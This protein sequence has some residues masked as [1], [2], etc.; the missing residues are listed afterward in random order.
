MRKESRSQKQNFEDLDDEFQEEQQGYIALLSGAL[1]RFYQEDAKELFNDGK[2]ID[3]R[4]M[5]GCIS[6][7]VWCERQWDEFGNLEP[8]VDV[9]YNKMRD[10]DDK[11]VEK[12]FDDC[13]KEDCDRRDECWGKIMLRKCTYSASCHWTECE[14]HPYGFR[15]D[16]IVHKRGSHSGDRNGMI[17]EFKKDRKGIAKR[18]VE[19]DIAKIEHGTC[20]DRAFRYKVGAFVLLK[21]KQADVY[22]FVNH[23]PAEMFT[24]RSDGRDNQDTQDEVAKAKHCC[25]QL[26]KLLTGLKNS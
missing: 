2:P 12:H 23:S 15:P 5:V 13:L 16:L 26:K 1:K 6:R 4:T 14:K 18:D 8:D 22:V 17:V 24:V 3:E 11:V 20:D 25:N 7:Y 19:F 9:E 21:Q 10:S